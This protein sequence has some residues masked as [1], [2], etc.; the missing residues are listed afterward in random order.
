[1]I[2][3]VSHDRDML[4]FLWV[5]DV[6][7]AGPEIALFRF[8]RVVF[9]VLASPFLLNATIDHLMK[10]M[11]SSEEQ[12]VQKFC[13]SIYVD[14]IATSLPDV[15]AAYQFYLKA[16]LHL[17]G[18]NFN[19]RKFETNSLELREK[20]A[21]NKKRSREG[22]GA[23]SSGDVPGQDPAVR[24]V[25]GIDWDI[26][27]DQLLFD[28]SEVA[29]L[30]KE[31][32]PTKRNVIS[33]ATRFYD[34]LGVISP[35]TVRFKQLF[36]K[37]CEKQVEWDEPLTRELLTEWESLTSD[38]Q[39]FAPIMIPRCYPCVLGGKSFSLTGF[40]DASQKAYAAIVYMRAVRGDVI[41]TQFLC[42]KTRV[43]P[44]KKITIPWLE[45]LS[46]LLL[47]RLISTVQRAL[48]PELQLE[49][50]HCYS[51]STVALFWIP[52]LDKEWK[53][54][55][56]NRVVEIWSLVPPSCWRHCA[57]TQ[58]PAD[59]PLRGVSSLELQGKMELWLRRPNLP[60]VDHNTG[61][62][63]MATL[64][65]ECLTEM[66]GKREKSTIVHPSSSA[67]IIIWH[68]S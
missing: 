31:M 47:A 34:P 53:Q 61:S 49:D 42:S 19:L 59:I 41:H 22:G 32:D 7:D 39:Q 38:L 16:K 50:I 66:R 12:F 15:D 28:V 51:D 54:F 46:V 62:E 1:M 63:E 45:L 29:C 24:Q 18:A 20:I 4:R 2:S 44:V 52:V 48:E 9:G 35:V 40:C 10:K 36:Q 17:K 60:I 56:M 67:R 68:C 13:R 3:V 55:V 37:L 14:D 8:T 6:N 25:L 65:Q 33:L 64:P 30:M 5:T 43:A 26:K 27:N 21:D 23:Q 57:G 11:D 58:N